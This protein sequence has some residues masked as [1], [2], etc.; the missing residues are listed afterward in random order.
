M[1]AFLAQLLAARAMLAQEAGERLLGRADARATLGRAAG[2]DRGR[3]LGDQCD[4]AGAMKG[5][6]IGGRQRR[7]RLDAQPSQVVGCAGLHAGRDFLAEQFEEEFRHRQS[8]DADSMS[9]CEKSSPLNNSG[10]PS[11]LATPYTM[12][13]PKFS[14]AGWRRLP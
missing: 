6:H 5:P 8:F 1:V 3:H 2:G 13:S 10:S 12:Q 4:A 9:V 7:Q 11:A 14:L